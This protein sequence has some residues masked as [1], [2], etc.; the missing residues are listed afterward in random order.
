MAESEE[1]LLK[2][3]FQKIDAEAEEILDVKLDTAIRKGMQQGNR[4]RLSFR[5]KYA[6]VVLVVLAFAL[7]IIVPWANQMINPVRAQLPPKS[8]GQLEVFRP[9][10]ANNLTIKSALDAGMMKE[11]N[12][13]SPEVDGITWTVNG[14][15]ADRRG[16]AVLYTIQNN[17]DQKMRLFGLSLKKTPEDKYH[18]SGYSGFSTSNAQEVGSPG[19]TRMYEQIVWDK[20]QDEIPEELN[21]TLSL[22]PDALGQVFNNKDIKEMDVKIPLEADNNYFQGELVDLKDS[23]SIGGQKIIMDQVYIG[24][25]GIYMRQTFGRENTMRIF[26]LLSPKLVLGKGDHQEELMWASGSNIYH[27]DNMRPD[28]PIKLEVEGISALDQ[29][30][31]ELVINTETQ[32][33]LKA[34][35][36]YLTISKRT[37]DEEKG[38]I[39]LDLLIPKKVEELHEA[40]GFGI[41]D[42]FVDSAGSGHWLVHD[43]EG[44]SRYREYREDAKGT[45][46][47]YFLNVGKE[48][49]PQPLTFRFTNYPNMIMET[50]SVR[51][52]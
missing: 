18:L 25:T 15:I 23:L 22:F 42:N 32:Q 51:I 37:A 34:P 44:Y 30:E 38:I 12:I 35:D 4:S 39:L 45:T 40:T 7:L 20:Y 16:I 50:D 13:S 49:L 28:D 43:S 26:S 17:T 5:K 11:V 1:K 14:I 48:K 10:I 24:P 31:V 46:I 21:I 36:N 29:S 9:V 8:W 6:V 41:D 33:I 19:T 27:N 3:Y 47:T 52:R 2:D